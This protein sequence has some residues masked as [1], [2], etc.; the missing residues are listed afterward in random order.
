[1]FSIQ[2]IV[3]ITKG[4]AIQLAYP[5]DRLSHL[6]IDSRKIVFA[7]TSLFFA[8]HGERHNGH[9]FIPELIKKGVRNF[10]VT[11]LPAL[12]T[13]EDN[14]TDD[15]SDSAGVNIILVA[16]AVL[17]LQEIAKA[18]RAKFH[19]PVIGITGSNGK[20]IVKEWLYQLLNTHFRIVRS[21]KSYN[22]QVGVPLSVWEMNEHH[23]LA[24]F[25]AGISTVGEMERLEQIIQPTIGIFT[26]VGSAHDE[27]FENREEK[28]KEKMKLFANCDIVFSTMN[29]PLKKVVQ[30]YQILQ[31]TQSDQETTFELSH[32]GEVFEFIV[33]STDQAT[34]ENSLTCLCL[35]LHFSIPYEEIQARFD[36]LRPVAMRLELKEAIN[37]SHVIDDSYNNDLSGL[38]MAL[39]FLKLQRQAGKTVVILSDMY[40]TNLPDDQLYA[41]IAEL[42]QQMEIDEFIGIGGRM[43]AH[44]YLFSEIYRKN[45]RTSDTIASQTDSEIKNSVDKLASLREEDES[46]PSLAY[47]DITEIQSNL[48]TYF[49][50]TTESFLISPLC[51]SLHNA[52]ILV[53]GARPFAFEQ[54]V[55]RLQ[56]KA[57]GTVLEI[58]LDAIT[59]NLNFYRSLIKPKTQIMAMVKAYAYGSGSAEVAQW[60][61]FH[62]VD[63]LGVAYVDEGVFLRK[64][65]IKLP[66]MVMN[67]S[68]ESFPLCVEHGLEPEIYSFKLLEDL[69]RFFKSQ[70][71][72]F[73]NFKI[74]IKLD[75]GMRRLGFEPDEVP[76][77]AKVLA[78]SLPWEVAVASVFSHLAV[79]DEAKHNAFSKQQIALFEKGTAILEEELGYSFL[80]HIAN[81]PAIVR[82]PE[83]H[84][85]MVRLGI[86]LYGVEASQISP[87]QLMP[88]ATFKTIISQLKHIKAGETV[89]YG[90]QGIAE[91]DMTIA[92][93]AVGYADGFLRRLSKGVGKVGV[94]GKVVPVVGNVCMDMSMIDVTGLEVS[95][96]DEVIIFGEAPNP[97][98]FDVAENL[99]TIPY[100]VLTLISE[101]VK[102]VFYTT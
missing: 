67:P 57:H 29:S 33:K 1:M 53:K 43:C 22:S 95:E 15:F 46:E 86:G 100:E 83:A 17:A 62:R 69:L 96:G 4:S 89:G 59:N 48:S 23:N 3:A 65:G 90:R 99:Q 68:A 72:R 25:E 13:H 2:E 87:D 36:A 75:T 101:R 21:P 39:N 51:N 30:N 64:N 74:H 35:M 27:G 80:K 19:Y 9:L 76:Q 37:H 44:Q 77:L 84:F 12:P 54:I 94:H 41:K 42:M 60:L 63:Y 93:I 16:D 92:T 20:T 14:Q 26:N 66:I 50:P 85:D 78:D 40:E 58:N 31:A 56:K 49:F 11:E 88:V 55:K 10:I 47:T 81:S 70:N 102:R 32:A 98:I 18:H 6:L 24:I 82:F 34:I 7:Q 5:Y 52:L 28:K 97:T 91:H 71:K 8:I 73:H 38:Q 45:A 61:Q 79:A